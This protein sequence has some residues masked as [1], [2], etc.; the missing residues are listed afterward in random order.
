MVTIP[1]DIELSLYQMT[2]DSGSRLVAED[3]AR[4]IASVTVLK[5]AVYSMQDYLVL[6]QQNENSM[7][8]ERVKRHYK[9]ACETTL[10][11]IKAA[12]QTIGSMR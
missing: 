12:L 8:D 3:Q 7:A 1:S 5:K 9:A 10:A 6:V 4:L 11:E 2:V